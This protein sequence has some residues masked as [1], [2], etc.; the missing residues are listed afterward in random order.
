MIAPFG[1]LNEAHNLLIYYTCEFNVL[2]SHLGLLISRNLSYSD[3]NSRFLS[4]F[5]RDAMSYVYVSGPAVES[6][7]ESSRRDFSVH[8]VL[9]SVV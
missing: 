9:C 1:I 5:R 3:H 4:Y 2:A 6:K 8:F 7:M